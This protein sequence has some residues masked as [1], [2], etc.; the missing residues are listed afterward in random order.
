MEFSVSLHSSSKVIHCDFIG[1]VKNGVVSNS[2]FLQTPEQLQNENVSQHLIPHRTFSSN[3]PSLS[4]L[5]PMCE[6]QSLNQTVEEIGLLTWIGLETERKHL[7]QHKEQT[8]DFGW[9]LSQPWQVSNVEQVKQMVPAEAERADDK[10]VVKVNNQKN[11]TAKTKKPMKPAT[12]AV[13]AP[14]SG[15]GEIAVTE[16]KEH[17]QTKKEEDLAR[18]VEEL[19]S[20]DVAMWREQGLLEEKANV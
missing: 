10:L 13:S 7:M 12:E 6:E 11:Q 17:K 9:T 4:L 20:E 1:V 14:V 2:S 15:R 18:K 3:Q 5:L 8:E 16:E 19:R